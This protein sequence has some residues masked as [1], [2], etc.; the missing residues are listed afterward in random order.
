MAHEQEITDPDELH[1][2]VTGDLDEKDGHSPDLYVCVDECYIYETPGDAEGNPQNDKDILY[3]AMPDEII[4]L[5]VDR[6]TGELKTNGE[7]AY[8]LKPKR[9]WVF[10]PDPTAEYDWG[11]LDEVFEEKKR[12]K[13]E[14]L[15][16]Q[17]A[18]EEGRDGG[19]HGD[20]GAVAT[21][22]EAMIQK[23]V[24]NYD[25]DGYMKSVTE[26]FLESKRDENLGQSD[27]GAMG[28]IAE[29][30]T[31][32]L[33]ARRN[34]KKQRMMAQ[35]KQL[36]FEE[37]SNKL[38]Q[39]K[40]LQQLIFYFR[41]H[42]FLPGLIILIIQAVIEVVIIF[43]V[44]TDLVVV[45]EIWE[46]PPGHERLVL[47]LVTISSALIVAP[48]VIAWTSLAGFNIKKLK[49]NRNHPGWIVYVLIFSICP[50]GV[51]FLLIT[52]IYHVIECVAIKPL[53]YLLTFGKEFR[54]ISY[55][56]LGYYKLRRVSEIFSEAMPQAIMQAVLLGSSLKTVLDLNIIVVLFGL[57]C[58]LVVLALWVTIIFVEG[59]KNGM[60]FAEYTTVVMQ[61]SFDFVEMLPA[62]ER[63]TNT[64]IRVN[65][66]KYKFAQDGVGHV[67]KALNSPQCKLELLKISKYTIR[68]LDRAQ[69]RF[70]GGALA[71]SKEQVEVILTR[72][73]SEIMALFDEYDVDHGK[74]LDF[75][76]FMHLSLD[77]KTK[78]NERCLRSDALMLYDALAD[79]VEHEVW[80]LDL[81]IKIK[82]SLERIGLLDYMF[83]LQHAFETK[84]LNLISL[85]MASQYDTFS[86]ETQLEFNNCVIEAVT[87][88][89]I[90][91]ALC[92]CEHK[93]VP[94]V[95]TMENGRGLIAMDRDGSS[96]PYVSVKMF[97]QMQRTKYIKQTLNP[98]WNEGLLFI[99]PF[100]TVDKMMESGSIQ[101]ISRNKTRSSTTQH[102]QNA[103]QSFAAI[104]IEGSVVYGLDLP[105]YAQTAI[106]QNQSEI[107]G[108][109]FEF[110]AAG[111]A[112]ELAQ[113]MVD[114][115]GLDRRQTSFA[116]FDSLEQS[117]AAKIGGET[118]KIKFQ[119]FDHDVDDEDDFMGS[120]KVN[121]N[122]MDD[123]S[124]LHDKV[125]TKKLKPPADQPIGFNAGTISLRIYCNV[126]DQYQKDGVRF[127][128]MDRG[129][130]SE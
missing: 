83:P 52:D 86:E 121:V 84:D 102:Q 49:Q 117:G 91:E 50:F 28:G 116:G 9:G 56:E 67:S 96:D 61:G 90:R 79:S 35:T 29:E 27:D 33:D 119:V 104:D 128:D 125:M 51:A 58:S 122:M 45:K 115:P 30:R 38:L 77:L 7:Y 25:E 114:A 95:V 66:T 63:G 74:S 65:W 127:I 89:H 36:E 10:L 93:G 78:V 21:D 108:K 113:T 76:E 48:Y 72:L 103:H 71:Q 57:I 14:Q 60:K 32:I 88:G 85:L 2:I 37:T 107:H 81:Q 22:S 98:D 111:S 18:K 13:M 99:I 41:R 70:L 1:E 4:Q 6:E 20:D 68:D 12:L 118:L 26:D 5:F 126:I 16:E 31:L 105:K 43:D 120:Y 101:E 82:G 17:K 46:A 124:K 94:L 106:V 123:Q 42:P 24:T 100:D 64:G 97:D 3:D 11:S 112:A 34:F 15:E 39:I 73:E 47:I 92:L 62:I 80:M 129:K 44:F 54:T 19:D 69:C 110:Q 59:K 53:W 87:N 23:N 130:E 8:C 109:T 75:D 55:D 40:K